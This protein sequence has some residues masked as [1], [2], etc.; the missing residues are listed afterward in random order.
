M[1]LLRTWGWI[2]GA[3]DWE[4][5]SVLRRLTSPVL[6]SFQGN[7]SFPRNRRRRKNFCRTF[8]GTLFLLVLPRTSGIKWSSEGERSWR[9]Y[10]SRLTFSQTIVS[11]VTAKKKKLLLMFFRLLLAMFTAHDVHRQHWAQH[12]DIAWVCESSHLIRICGCVHASY[13]HNISDVSL[14]F[15]SGNGAQ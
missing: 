7:K 10:K 11:E 2:Y 12:S 6:E 9:F 5:F 15:T 8:K 4:I 14:M 3:C 1:R 13:R